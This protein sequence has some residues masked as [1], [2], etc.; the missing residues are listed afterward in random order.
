M[1]KVCMCPKVKLLMALKILAYGVAPAAFQAYF[2][3]GITS[4][5]VCLKSFASFCLTMIAS[6]A[7]KA[8]III[9]C[10]VL[11]LEG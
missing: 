10:L 7:S 11:M 4:A 9:K 3:M 6:K 5:H 2:Q 1:G 8:Y